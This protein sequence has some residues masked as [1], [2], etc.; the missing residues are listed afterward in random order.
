MKAKRQFEVMLNSVSIPNGNRGTS[1]GY[2]FE[3]IIDRPNVERLERILINR[4]DDHNY[5]RLKAAEVI[6]K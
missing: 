3:Q 6:D 5:W 2:W 4:R 1:P